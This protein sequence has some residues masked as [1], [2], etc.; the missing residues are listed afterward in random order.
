MTPIYN[1]KIPKS[2]IDV[3]AKLE[4]KNPT[5]THKDRS[6]ERW[7]EHYAKQ[8]IREFAICSSGNSAKSAAKVCREKGL[9]LRIFVS[10]NTWEPEHF[11][12]EGGGIKVS[13]KSAPKKEAFQYA[14]KHNI[15]NLRASTDDMALLGYKEITA[16]L[17]KDISHIDNIFISTSS[18]ATLEG[19]HQGF[20]NASHI[21]AF[22]VVQT[23]RVHPIA[24]YFDK[25]FIPEHTSN[26]K[27]I[28]DRIAHRRDKII[29]ICSETGGGGFVISNDELESARGVLLE[30]SW[31]RRDFFRKVDT[32]I[33]ELQH[34]RW[35]SILSFAGFLK[36][37]V[38]NP[39]KA[40]KEISVCLFTD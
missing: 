38:Q 3:W 21:P 25:D 8:G 1:I 24:S 4:S 12:H 40:S 37:R 7:I 26:A 15:P 10:R 16:E 33:G 14:K 30:D 39:E 5:G 18:G 34:G 28:V 19:M 11:G 31:L 23:T 6:M 36:W 2:N 32:K 27:A 13:F 9:G 29:K 17:I 22:F 35:Q 20:K